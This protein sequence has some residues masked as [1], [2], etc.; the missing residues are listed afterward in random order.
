MSANIPVAVLD[1]DRLALR[2]RE[3]AKALSISE[4]TLWSLTKEG[5]IPHIRIGR[6]IVYPVD[7]LRAWL[8]AKAQEGQHA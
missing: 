7:S 5:R 1:K 3:A 8:A 4:R 2:P 6:A